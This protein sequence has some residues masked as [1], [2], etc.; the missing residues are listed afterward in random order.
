ME[1]GPSGG[2]ARD[3]LLL[4]LGRLRESASPVDAVRRLLRQGPD[5]RVVEEDLAEHRESRLVRRHL[6]DP[7]VD[8]RIE[9]HALPDTL[10]AGRAVALE[11]V[12]LTELRTEER[13]VGPVTMV[14]ETE[15]RARARLSPEV[16]ILG[17]V[18]SSTRTLVRTRS[19]VDGRDSGRRPAPP[20]E[21]L[22]MLR[23]L[24][25]GRDRPG[26]LPAFLLR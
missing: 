23:C 7:F 2:L 20:L 14:I 17:L 1:I 12:V 8:P 21:N 18:D 22:R 25:F 4:D 5:G 6:E 13:L 11:S 24:A 16:P 3:F 26:P 19:R 9:R 15:L 10:L